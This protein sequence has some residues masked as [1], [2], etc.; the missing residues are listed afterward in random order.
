[1]RRRRSWRRALITACAAAAV[2]L[3]AAWAV[4]GWLEVRVSRADSSG[5][6]T[7]AIVLGRVEVAWW[8]MP[9]PEN[10]GLWCKAVPWDGWRWRF[11]ERTVATLGVRSWTYW[12]PLWPAVL[13]AAVL[14]LGVAWLDRRA[15]AA[16]VGRCGRC[17]YD[18]AGI[19]PT[20]PCPECGEVPT[21]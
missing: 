12:I 13:L 15:R 4:S 18:R 16:G 21:P 5:T 10:N 14:A 8:N 20:S 19:S 6:R 2:L 17:G 3:A 9:V 1:M 7:V 11:A